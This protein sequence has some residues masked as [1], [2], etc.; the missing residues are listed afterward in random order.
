MIGTQSYLAFITPGIIL[1]T[2]LFG[3]VF[4]GLSVVWDRRIGYLEELMA[5]PISRGSIPLGKMLAAA[6]QGG[7]RW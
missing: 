5:A 7:C 1:L 2:V 6:V 4:A 3:G